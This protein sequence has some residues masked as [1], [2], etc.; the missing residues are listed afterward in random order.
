M[1]L[2]SAPIP[3]MEES[4][5][6]H[7]SPTLPVRAHSSNEVSGYRSSTTAGD[8][9]PKCML[10]ISDNASSRVWMSQDPSIYSNSEYVCAIFPIAVDLFWDKWGRGIV[11]AKPASM[12]FTILTHCLHTTATNNYFVRAQG[13]WICLGAIQKGLFLRPL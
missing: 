2:L 11:E 9:V 6:A 3:Q 12:I 7:V 1:S 10:P 5:P 4:A 8:A 13:Q